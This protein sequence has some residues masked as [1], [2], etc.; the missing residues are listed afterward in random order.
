MYIKCCLGSYNVMF[1]PQIPLAD[2]GARPPNS[3]GP[4]IFFYVQNAN[5]SHFFLRLSRE[6]ILG[7]QKLILGDMRACLL[8]Q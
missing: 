7:R 5:F 1:V 4:M 3:R 8:R 2:P 6:N